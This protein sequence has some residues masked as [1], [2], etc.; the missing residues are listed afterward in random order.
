MLDAKE[1]THWQ[2]FFQFGMIFF[3]LSCSMTQKLQHSIW[4]SHKHRPKQGAHNYWKVETETHTGWNWNIYITSPFFRF[5]QLVHKSSLTSVSLTLSWPFKGA[6]KVS[7]LSCPL[8]FSLAHR[9]LVADKWRLFL[10]HSL[11]LLVHT[12]C[13]IVLCWLLMEAGFKFP[14]LVWICISSPLVRGFS[15]LAPW[16]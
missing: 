3:L 6:V 15:C 4:Q 5:L 9:G 10:Q 8:G 13:A 16:L 1:I 7:G 11:P 2:V 12:V 14:D